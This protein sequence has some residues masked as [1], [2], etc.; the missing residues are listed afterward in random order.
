LHVL[1]EQQ[2]QPSEL[3]LLLVGSKNAGKTSLVSSLVNE[4]LVEG[5]T[6]EN[7]M[8]INKVFCKNWKR[9]NKANY[10]EDQFIDQ[11][12]QHM[13]NKCITSLS[14]DSL[15]SKSTA[16]SCA[17]ERSSEFCSQAI[18]NLCTTIW[19]FNNDAILHNAPSA[20]I[21]EHTVSVITFDASKELTDEILLDEGSY[22]LPEC[23]NSIS[24]IHY[25]LKVVD[26]VCSVEG[27]DGHLQPTAILAGTHIDKLHSDLHV[28]RKIARDRIL[29]LLE[30]E[31]FGKRYARHL[32][33][34]SKGIKNALQQFC[35]FISN[36]LHDEEIERLKNT[37]IEAAVPLMKYQPIYIL[38][39]EAE[40]LQC[41]E[42][43]IS[44]RN[45]LDLATKCSIPMAENSVDFED[46]L[47]CLHEKRAILYFNQIKSLKNLVILSPWWISKLLSYTVTA[48]YYAVNGCGQES[49]FHK[50]SVLHE[51]L[52]QRLEVFDSDYPSAVRVTEIQVKGTL[53]LLGC[54]TTWFSEEG[55]SLLSNHEDAIIVPFRVP[56]DDRKC[57]PD[58]HLQRIIYFKFDDGFVPIDL[59]DKLIARCI[60]HTVKRKRKLLWYVI[61]LSTKLL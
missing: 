21:S 60:C 37:A 55:Y 45:M 30:K 15:V 3:Q 31:L 1:K 13:I 22:Q 58:T 46:L 4:E 56:H 53:H 29:P 5:A 7:N 14:F 6:K 23:H 11:V 12:T 36:R 54:Y 42:H 18:D 17:I 59:L 2:S 41:R 16:Y 57:P 40:L 49:C 20:F 39:V 10:L 48:Y 9:I 26:S 8:A 34:Y 19:D 43:V 50:Y 51:S 28:A 38:K 35:F 24:S 33:G 27:E 44:K 25:W 52:L 47:R 32:A 61:V